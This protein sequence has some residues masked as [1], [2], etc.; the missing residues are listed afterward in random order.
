MCC[1]FFRVPRKNNIAF[2]LWLCLIVPFSFGGVFFPWIVSVA[3][4]CKYCQRAR[5]YVFVSPLIHLHSI[6]IY[7]VFCN[8]YVIVRWLTQKD[9]YLIIKYIVR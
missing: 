5:V 4:Q 2:M 8:I 3:C 9:A 7:Y 1:L 6:Y